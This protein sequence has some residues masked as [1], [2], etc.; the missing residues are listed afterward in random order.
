MA[1]VIK[2]DAIKDLNVSWENYAGQSV[3]DFI[4]GQLKQH[5]GYLYR[6]P[7][8]IGDYYYIY[9]FQSLE[10]FN[11]WQTKEDDKLILFR[12]QLP[13]VENDSFSVRLETNS[14]TNKL[15]NL[16]DGIK[17]NLRYTSVSENP[18]T[19]AITDT[20]N[21]GNL[22]ILRSANGSAF[23]EV[24]RLTIQPIEHEKTEEFTTVDITNYLADGSNQ[25]RLRVEDSVNG[26]VSNNINF[27]EIINTSLIIE[28]AMDTSKPLKQPV[29][30]FYIQ[31][32][33]QKTLNVKI[34]GDSL[35]GETYSQPLGT[36]TYIEVPYNF[37]IDDS[38][39]T[40]IMQI[41]AWLSVDDTT[42]ESEHI[43][44]QMYY[45]DSAEE[46]CVV[47][48]NNVAKTATN[49]TT[50]HFLDFT[51]YNKRSDVTITI[52]NGFNNYLSYTYTD[53][54]TEK[55]Y[56]YSN[57]LEVNSSQKTIPATI[58]VK[59]ADMTVTEPLTIDNSMDMNPVKNAVF[60]LNPKVRDNGEEEPNKIIN[61]ATEVV[62]DSNFTGFKFA[63]GDGW[64]TGD[65]GV[66][67]LR[68]P[69]GCKLDFDYDALDSVNNGTTI[70]LDYKVYNVFDN[71]DI[72]LRF[73]NY[74]DNGNP[75]GFEMKA[76][77]ASFMTNNKQVRRDQDVFFCEGNR[78]HLAINIVPNL[79]NTGLNYV[80]IFINGTINRE[81]TYSDDDLFKVDD[82]PTKFYIGAANSDIDIYNIRIYKKSL[83]A[84]EVR[85]NYMSSL[86]T[87][88]QKIDY[89]TKNDIL[90]ANET[91]SYDKAVVKYNT[92]VWTG[93][94]PSYSTG[95]VKFKGNLQINI[96]GDPEHSGKITNLKISGQGSSSRSYWKWNHG[97]DYTKD[98]VYTNGNGEVVNDGY[99]LRSTN[100]A[101]KSLVSKLNWAS[102]MQ[103]HKMGS[104][105]L[106]NDLHKAVIGGNSINKTQGYENYRV[107]IDEI[108]FLY[109]VREDE[110]S[111]PVFYGLVTIGEA[112]GGGEAYV[113]TEAFPEWAMF[114]GSDNGM[115]L[116]LR[117]VPW[118]EDEV[119]YNEDEEYFEYAGSGN[120]DFDGGKVENYTYLRDAYNF[121]YLHSL[122]LVPYNGDLEVLNSSSTVDTS[123]QYYNKSTYDV[124]RYDWISNTWVDAGMERVE[125]YIYHYTTQDDVDA[126][127]ATEVGKLVVEQYPSYSK[128][129]LVTQ[130][131]VVTTGDEATDLAA[132]IAW[133]KRDFKD[134]VS[135]YY[136]VNDTL[137]NMAFIKL[138]AASDNW[139]KNTYEYVDPKTK[140]LCWLNDDLDTIFLTDNVGRKT[141]PYYVEEHD[142]N[143]DQAYFNGSDN[144]FFNLMESCFQ[145][146]YRDVMR[147][148]FNAMNSTEFGGSAEAC[149]DRYFFST[150]KYFP[151]VAYNE[152]ARLLYEEASV[153][154][155]TLKPD[156]K[157]YM[158]VNGTP[159]ITQSLGDQYQAELGWWRKRQIYLSS[160]ARSNPFAVRST[161][162]LF[163]RSTLKTDSTRPSYQFE[164]TPYQWLYPKVGIGQTLGSD[165][166]RVIAGNSYQTISLTTDGNTD[167]FIY[168]ADYYTNFGEFGAHS[169]GE[170]FNLTGGRLLEFSADSRKVTSYQ[171]RPTSMTV[172]CPVLRKLVLYGASTLSSSLDL[173]ST[174]KLEY[175]DLRGT[176]L[177]S[178]IL[179]ATETLTKV[180][181]PNLTSVNITGVPNLTDFYVESTSRLT[182]LTTDNVKIL[183]QY[184][185]GDDISKITELH[186]NSITI[187]LS[188]KSSAISDNMY[189]LLI[190]PNSTATG[191]IT[192]NKTLT[193]EEQQTLIQKYG[194]IDNENNALYVRYILHT[195]DDLSITGD[196]NITE[197]KSKVYSV[198]YSGND[199]RAY[200]W[201]VQN[202][203]FDLI[204]DYTIRVKAVGNADE[205]IIITCTVKR[206]RNTDL[207]DIK[208]VDMIPYKCITGIEMSDFNAYR[209]GTYELQIT[210]TPDDLSVDIQDVIPTLT[211]VTTNV[212]I[213]SAS[214]EKIVIRTTEPTEDLHGTLRVYVEDVDGNNAEKT[215]NISVW[216][217]VALSVSA[218]GEN[219]VDYGNVVEGEN[220][221]SSKYV[222]QLDTNTFT[223]SVDVP[224]GYELG[225][226]TSSNTDIQIVKVEDNTIYFKFNAN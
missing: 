67:V 195:Q 28:N 139:C 47:I 224:E 32:Q 184:I 109:L 154:E 48:L 37:V 117:Q 20:Y 105:R 17:I 174:K 75:I 160:W 196:D 71:N 129:N 43:R 217:T 84:S 210:H 41:E 108:P 177:S 13:N 42:L 12:I 46:D 132:F 62:I 216:K 103:S 118:I 138:V 121:T 191:R 197:T 124:Y 70:E 107:A 202:S 151:S 63:G 153:M 209:P 10:D 159:A 18:V 82:L 156:G 213:I 182:S 155:K 72:M 69:A 111:Q 102:S 58:T 99:R 61:S 186:M 204:N 199:I 169:I 189:T 2:T 157:S 226:V 126:G 23:T 38:F 125:D 161:G 127:T 134:N 183:E 137:F 179:P 88:E 60:H 150:Q 24:G 120:I 185:A 16:G 193:L 205:N 65:D 218:T 221:Q 56:S 78:E 114:E 188:D 180:Y 163:F 55:T 79:A 212:T 27:N 21:P 74:N 181:L 73:C 220:D 168:G 214:L 152:T 11:K 223:M 187:D 215:I 86:P 98:T 145:T 175:L 149:M 144:V 135:K 39:Q 14:N 131:K 122:S 123:K 3:E 119:T 93:K 207:V 113:D 116:T 91:I 115:P 203:E 15:V 194:N 76:S 104:C 136:N 51:I 7:V 40:G 89:K 36:A 167:T 92:L 50:T 225:N 29:L 52:G 26:T 208:T 54:E 59:T 25:I 96:L 1:T 170:A 22:I 173:S 206:L 130:T 81:F 211:G 146:E 158:Y 178:V 171:F 143:G 176:G 57:V 166:T 85:Q 198:S 35:S 19:H 140:K 9:A 4:K 8:K 90:S 95:K 83:S 6:T 147:S 30:Q 101:V 68:V 190:K 44:I 49:Y 5:V 53:C 192:L 87:N 165:N 33:V 110:N 148:I 164:L 77:E 112:K 66:K 64:V 34:S 97:Y 141:K 219:S 100:P 45:I 128:L 80:R 133:R 106:F 31:G 222:L 172:A 201:D 94:V 200:I 142:M 162:S